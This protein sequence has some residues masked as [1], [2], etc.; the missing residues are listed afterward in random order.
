MESKEIL[1]QQSILSSKEQL[2]IS[3]SIFSKYKSRLN[4]CLFF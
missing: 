2:M 3:M 4:V 1:F